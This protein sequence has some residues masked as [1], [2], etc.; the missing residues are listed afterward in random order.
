MDYPQIN[1]AES[2]VLIRMEMA[3]TLQVWVEESQSSGK[4]APRL[5]HIAFPGEIMALSTLNASYTRDADVGSYTGHRLRLY[6]ASPF[7]DSVRTETYAADTRE[8]PLRHYRLITE[9]DIID[10]ITL[11]PP[12]VDEI[13]LI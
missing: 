1:H 2:L 4:R 11:T 13:T 10:V 7:L 12:H 3:D 6:E 5:F 8:H 9:E